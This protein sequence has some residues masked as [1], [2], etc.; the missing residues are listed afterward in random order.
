MGLAPPQIAEPYD[1]IFDQNATLNMEK[2]IKRAI[3]CELKNAV[4]TV[5]GGPTARHFH[6]GEDQ[7]TN[8]DVPLAIIGARK[9]RSAF[10]VDEKSAFAPGLL[11]KS[12]CMMRRSIL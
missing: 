6:Y 8:V 5:K 11:L 2:Q 7:T 1:R 10:T 3:Y 12:P 9:S 4:R